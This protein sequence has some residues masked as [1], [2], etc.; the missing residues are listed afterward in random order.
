[1]SQKEMNTRLTQQT[2]SLSN[3][4][5][6]LSEQLSQKEAS[7]A[8]EKA[9]REEAENQ[10]KV[11]EEWAQQKAKQEERI[12]QLDSEVRRLE[13]E[14]RELK[15]SKSTSDVPQLLV[16]A[17]IDGQA[18]KGAKLAFAGREWTLPAKI[19]LHP[20][21]RY[22]GGTVRCRFHGIDYCG[23]LDPFQ[24]NWNGNKTATVMLVKESEDDGAD[25]FA[26]LFVWFAEDD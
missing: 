8:R 17:T 16:R 21:G 1:M 20:N 23:T 18:I 14:L 13:N 19:V 2:T 15:N 3:Q 6:F 7:F 12:V 10:L 26:D 24:A 11:Q 9:A 25:E 22:Q 5:D 4:V